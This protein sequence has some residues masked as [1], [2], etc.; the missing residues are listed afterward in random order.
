MGLELERRNGQVVVL[1]Q[2]GWAGSWRHRGSGNLIDDHVI[3]CSLCPLAAPFLVVEAM[4]RRLWK[5]IAATTVLIGTPSYL[6]YR[7][8]KPQ[9][10]DLPV[11]IL[12]ADGTPVMTSK[13]FPLLSLIA[14]DER[15]NRNA[16][17]DTITRP[18]GITW[19]YSTAS[20]PANEPLEDAHAEAII[21]REP[22]DPQ[23]PGD[24]LFFAVM[25]GHGGPHTSRLLS[26]TLISAVVLQL[27]SLIHGSSGSMLS[28]PRVQNPQAIS[29]AIQSAFTKLDEELIN[30]PLKIL[31]N[32]IDKESL[33]KKIVPDLSE[34]PL[35][36]PVMLPAVSGMLTRGLLQLHDIQT[37]FRQ[38]CFDGCL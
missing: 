28:R 17:S 20:L 13:T 27:S 3:R 23:G 34:H 5:P 19:K 6:Y 24:W 11:K 35:A 10:F 1:T 37:H 14:I 36:L 18:G 12:G 2:V 26:N 21:A 22:S 29:L 8:N 16:K 33:K 9:T 25:D 30:A 4:L 15:L 38:L 32:N 31:A 7:Y